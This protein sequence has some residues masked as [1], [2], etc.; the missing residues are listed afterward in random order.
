M[1]QMRIAAAV[2]SALLAVLL[3]G[4]GPARAAG[5]ELYAAIGDSYSS[6]VGAPPYDGTTCARSP[7]GYPPQYAA[8]RAM[9][10][11]LLACSGATTDD[12]LADQIPL[13][14]PETIA[15]T[16]TVGGDDLDF[17]N[18][19][20]KC[21]RGTDAECQQVADA[22]HAYIR[23]TLPGKLDEVYQAV[24]KQARDAWLG[25]LGYP[26]LFAPG[27]ECLMDAAKQEMINEVGRH[28]NAVIEERAQANGAVFGDAAKWFDGHGM[29]TVDPWIGPDFH[30]NRE[31]YYRGYLSL[32]K[33]IG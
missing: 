5:D 2:S 3:V 23:T 9:I 6:G 19:L 4:P 13:M 17:T 28:L 16:V 15:V 20:L 8:Y 29:C 7:H 18:G 33:Y 11:D 27:S 24:R 21:Y 22:A 31:G 30:P 12:V 14:P 1:G 10:L 26:L 32:M 25:V